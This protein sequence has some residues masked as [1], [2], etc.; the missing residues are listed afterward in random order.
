MVTSPL[1]DFEPTEQDIVDCLNEM[2]N[3]FRA[4]NGFT[5]QTEPLNS[6]GYYAARI[7]AALDRARLE[8][9]DM[10]A[11]GFTGDPTAKMI[12]LQWELEAFAELA[13]IS[14]HVLIQLDSHQERDAAEGDYEGIADQVAELSE[15]V[16]PDCDS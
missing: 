1:P 15:P 9:I 16:A 5:P 3:E 6:P 12:A 2:E 4:H 7:E 10:D 8:A 13:K 14:A 11:K